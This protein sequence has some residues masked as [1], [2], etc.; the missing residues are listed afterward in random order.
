VGK[1]KTGP[2]NVGAGLAVAAVA[3]ISLLTS[4]G[5]RNY[6]IGEVD[7]VEAPLTT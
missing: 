1:A 7:E 5:S 6:V 4:Q 3:L 2:A